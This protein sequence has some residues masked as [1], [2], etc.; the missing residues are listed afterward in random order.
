MKLYRYTNNVNDSYKIN[1][2][3]SFD[4][5]LVYLHE[6]DVIK[7][8]PCGSWIIYR[9]VKKFVN[10]THRKQFAY[11]SRDLALVNFLARKNSQIRIL[12]AQ[13][14][15]AEDSFKAIEKGPI[16][17]DAFYRPDLVADMFEY[18]G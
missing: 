4:T 5:S 18:G 9:E 15:V 13:I 11:K 8:T 1:T 6:F 3:F 12:S 16:P 10:H 2:M 17:Y 7:V 14:K